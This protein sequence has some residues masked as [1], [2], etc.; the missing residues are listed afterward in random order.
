[1]V[2]LANLDLRVDHE[3]LHRGCELSDIP[4]KHLCYYEQSD[5]LDVIDDDTMHCNVLSKEGENT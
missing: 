4:P 2:T 5:G 1:M 3:P